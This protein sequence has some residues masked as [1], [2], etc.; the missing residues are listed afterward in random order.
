MAIE[1]IQIS[2]PDYVDIVKL[3]RSIQRAEGKI[4][5]YRRGQQRCSDL[6]CVWRTHC[7]QARKKTFK[8]A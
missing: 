4:D 7:L 3:V 5:C 6:T 8:S 1:N 2:K